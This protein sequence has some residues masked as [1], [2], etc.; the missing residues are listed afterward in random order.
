MGTTVNGE[1]APVN[2]AGDEGRTAP[3]PLAAGAVLV[4]IVD[5][6]GYGAPPATVVVAGVEAGAVPGTRATGAVGVAPATPVSVVKWT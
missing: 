2:S 1:A 5:G 4:P 3:V 6:I